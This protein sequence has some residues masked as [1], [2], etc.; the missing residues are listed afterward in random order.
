MTI[1]NITAGQEIAPEFL[2]T[3]LKPDAIA[4]RAIGLL[5]NPNLLQTQI[6]QQ[7]HALDKMGIGKTSAANLA[8]EAI[9]KE[10]DEV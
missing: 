8:A 2:Q 10:L 4:E 6:E 9:F 3:K 5:K 7:F 1:L